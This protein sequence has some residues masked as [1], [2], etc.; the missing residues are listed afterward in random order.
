MKKFDCRNWVIA[1]QTKQ[2][3]FVML[4]C[5]VVLLLSMVAETSAVQ[6]GVS[7]PDT[8]Q[9]QSYT[10]TFGEDSDY[11][12]NPPSYTENGDGTVTDNTTGLVWQQQDGGQ[13]ITNTKATVY[14]Q[15]LSLSGSGWRLPSIGELV[16]I[17]NYDRVAPSIDPIFI[18]TQSRNGA[19]YASST[20]WAGNPNGFCGLNFFAGFAGCNGINSINYNVKCVRGG[21]NSVNNYKAISGEVTDKRTGLVWKQ[22]NDGKIRTWSEAIDYCNGLPPTN[23]NFWR[24][25]NIKELQSIIDHS[26]INPAIDPIFPGTQKSA[27]WSSTSYANDGDIGPTNFEAWIVKFHEDYVW[28]DNKRN[29]NYVRCVRNGQSNQSVL[30]PPFSITVLSSDSDGNFNVSWAVSSTTGVTYILQESTDSGFTIGIRDAYKGNKL[31]APITGRIMGK[32]YYYRVKAIKSG[33]TDSEWTPAANGCNLSAPAAVPG[34]ITVPAKDPDGSYI[35]KWKASKTKGVSY[36]LEEATDKKFTANLREV[37]T[38]TSLQAPITERSNKATY[39]YR[40]KATKTG[41]ADSAWIADAKGCAVTISAPAGVQPPKSITVVQTDED[42]SYPVTWAPSPTPGVTYE[43]EEATD[44]KFTLG[45]RPV[46]TGKEKG[47]TVVGRSQNVTY[48]Y[49][50]R[51]VN[52]SSQASIWQKAGNGCLVAV[53]TP[54][55][56]MQLNDD[57]KSH[58]IADGYDG[59]NFVTIK[60]DKK[61][62]G[63]IDR[64]TEYAFVAEDDSS[65]RLTITVDDK[66]R[67]VSLLSEKGEVKLQYLAGNKLSITGKANDGRAIDPQ[68]IDLPQAVAQVMQSSSIQ[69]QSA[70]SMAA[71]DNEFDLFHKTG[72]ILVQCDDAEHFPTETFT[73]PLPS[74][75]QGPLPPKSL[76]DAGYIGQTSID[77]KLTTEYEYKYI[78][79]KLHP[80]PTWEANCSKN[81][82]KLIQGSIVTQVTMRVICEA[83]V[84]S[85]LRW[86]L[87]DYCMQSLNWIGEK[88]SSSVMCTL[89]KYEE[90][91][92]ELNEY[93]TIDITACKKYQDGTTKC[94]GPENVVATTAKELPEFKL[95]PAPP[96]AEIQMT[97]GTAVTL[98]GEQTVTPDSL[99]QFK[100]IDNYKTVNGDYIDGCATYAWKIVN[101]STK[102]VK[103]YSSGNGRDMSYTFK[104]PGTYEI[105]LTVDN[106]EHKAVTTRQKIT[107]G[108]VPVIVVSQASTPVISGSTGYTFEREEIGHEQYIYFSIRNEGDGDLI[109]ESISERDPDLGI[110]NVGTNSI[111]PGWYKNFTVHWTPKSSAPLN[112]L[113]IV[114]SNDPKTPEF[115][116]NVVGGDSCQNPGTVM[117]KGREWQRCGSQAEMS[118]DS[119]KAYCAN[120]T[121]DGHD[122]WFL[123]SIDTLVS[124]IVCSDGREVVLPPG[125]SDESYWQVWTY[126]CEGPLKLGVKNPAFTSFLFYYWSSTPDLMYSHGEKTF[127]ADFYYGDIV[128]IDAG[129]ARCVRGGP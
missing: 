117:W 111:P 85:S 69:M 57:P 108:S 53:A 91:E 30:S 125:E 29:G 5:S 94:K 67:P 92:K 95:G 112:A 66:D 87:M 88:A 34:A 106:H 64:I 62:D 68:T 25:P 129:G 24:L 33:S 97:Y 84:P 81:M 82:G 116:F 63:S 83:V 51:A 113:V 93:G 6:A 14:C 72:T 48:Y 98:Q 27:Y 38:G 42:G 96:K 21:Q 60:G 23:Q 118:F 10:D 77:G 47:F 110:V 11:E 123:P 55:A 86:L 121:E 100:A 32:T 59:R 9:T 101:T 124:L 115:S 7:I 78:V 36:T 1:N 39:Y 99:V 114:K 74:G 75:Q 8:G 109:I 104:D 56:P 70:N 89:A 20:S 41:L 22:K 18:G 126:G 79:K 49:R 120:L 52:A 40:V 50:V 46:Y 122:D 35:L 19:N 43:L 16:G 28:F 44:N 54:D 80:Y 73:K 61:P 17:V 65:K 71:E 45:K 127:A 31:V 26:R 102:P 105:T 103:E 90:L 15:D 12:I 76:D 107:V 2:S 13:T 4:A 3:F 119:A 58:I 128:T 37:Y